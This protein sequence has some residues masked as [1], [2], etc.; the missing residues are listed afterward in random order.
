MVVRVKLGRLEAGLP[1]KEKRLK[2]LRLELARD[3]GEKKPLVAPGSD[4]TLVV[5]AGDTP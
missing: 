1:L 3:A 5:L 4:Q 2:R